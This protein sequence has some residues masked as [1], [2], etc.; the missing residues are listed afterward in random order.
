MHRAAITGRDDGYTRAAIAQHDRYEKARTAWPCE[1]RKNDVAKQWGIQ[2]TKALEMERRRNMELKLAQYIERDVLP[3]RMNDTKLGGVPERMR[4]CRTHGCWGWRP[5]E[6]TLVTAWD[7]KC[8]LVRLC[9]HEARAEAK[10][11][12]ERYLPAVMDQINEGNTVHFAVLTS[13]NVK[14]D[15]LAREKKRLFAAFNRML[16][17]QVRG[18]PRLP[19]IGS[20]VT[21]EDPQSSWGEWNVH[22]NCFLVARGWLDYGE[23]RKAW[24]QA[25]K[26]LDLNIHIERLKGGRDG[27]A[28]AFRE[29]VKYAGAPVSSKSIE[30]TTYAAD[31]LDVSTGELLTHPQAGWHRCG[32]YRAGNGDPQAPPMLAWSPESW[33]EWWDAQ[34]RFR[35]TR[36][37]GCLFKTPKPE[38]KGMHDVEWLGVIGWHNG[39]Y[40]TSGPLCL[41]PGDKSTNHHDPPR[42][43]QAE[44]FAPSGVDEW[45][46][47]YE[48]TPAAR[49]RQARYMGLRPL[50]AFACSI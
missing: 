36:S 40:K 49:H 21:Q 13:K 41:A 4:S 9:P 39:E 30:K 25:N 14:R 28:A 34:Q 38:P 6:Q 44:Q 3:L 26:A 46:T 48:G 20:L 42:P 7:D 23:L 45:I 5:A 31:Q 2:H 19:I 32:Q 10:R 22:I 29:L 43:Y 12:E 47:Q 15:R 8:G 24:A 18:R 37:Y 11:I 27:I 33:L 1:L 50:N 16:K 35:R 17:Q